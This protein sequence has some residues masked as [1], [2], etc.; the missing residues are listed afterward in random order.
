MFAMIKRIAMRKRTWVI[1]GGV[2]AGI[3]QA[4]TGDVP[5]AVAQVAHIVF[6]G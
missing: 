2:A 1:V 6:G 4:I 3:A 5:G